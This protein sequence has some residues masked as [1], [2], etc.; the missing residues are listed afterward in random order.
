MNIKDRIKYLT[1]QHER[2]DLSTTDLESKL[3]ATP[4]DSIVALNLAELKRK[5]LSVKDELAHLMK[6]DHA[7]QESFDF[8]DYDR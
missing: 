3:N 1:D 4:G 8:Y 6:S 7:D 2:L 5:K